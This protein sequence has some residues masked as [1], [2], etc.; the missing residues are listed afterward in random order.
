MTGAGE[1]KLPLNSKV[2]LDGK[3]IGARVYIYLKGYSLARVTHLDIEHPSL[4]LI[5]P[6]IGKFLMIRGTGDGIKLRVKGKELELVDAILKEVLN[7]GER[8]RTWVGGKVRGIYI[9]FRK[10]RMEKLE[11]IARKKFEIELR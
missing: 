7:S 2:Y 8:M 4:E 11:L 1:G 10:G 5:P 6:K 3:E 9:G